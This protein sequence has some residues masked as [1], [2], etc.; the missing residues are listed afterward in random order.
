[1]SRTANGFT[2]IELMI[3]VAIIGI[4]AG[5]ALPA[6]QDYTVRAKMSEVI[7]AMSGCRASV[8]EV[9]QSGGSP[10][11]AGNWGCEGITS[12]YVASI[13]TDVDGRVTATVQSINASVNTKAVTMIPLAS[14]TAFAASATDLGKGL[15][16]WLCGGAGTTLDK[17]F[18]PSSCR[19]I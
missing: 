15:Y 1:M 8:Q 2:L 12:H 3:T 7:L 17:K 10:P 6:Y 13:A 19:G 5:I 9:Y 11:G 4:I 14:A 16:G 18:L